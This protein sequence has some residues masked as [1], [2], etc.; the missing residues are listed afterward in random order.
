MRKSK[1]VGQGVGGGRKPL[2]ASIHILRGNP[3]SRPLREEPQTRELPN[4][5][6]P[7]WLRPEAQA[8]WRII[9]GDLM[10]MGVLRGP[11][12][13]AL[14]EICEMTAEKVRLMGLIWG[15]EIVATGHIDAEP[16]PK[17]RR[18]K[19]NNKPSSA[20][21]KKGGYR[22]VKAHPLYPELRNVQ[23]MLW[24]AWA[25]FGMT[26]SD[27]TRLGVTKP[28]GEAE[29]PADEFRAGGRSR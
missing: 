21:P 16:A 20:K 22:T 15:H 3:S 26:P 17:A 4:S 6:P 27:R 28:G 1:G 9:V 19:A 14:A 5:E 29:D 10:Y 2:P 7:A 13:L 25:K 24:D 8:V 12:V 11:D 23:K 18:G